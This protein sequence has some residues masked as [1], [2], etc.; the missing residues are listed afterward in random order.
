MKT[1][2]N[3]DLRIGNLVATGNILSIV[4][5]ITASGVTYDSLNGSVV[6]EHCEW[7]DV[8]GVELSKALLEKYGFVDKFD[9]DF[10]DE[11]DL[12]YDKI[13]GKESI[14]VSYENGKLFV[15]TKSGLELTHIL[16]F[17]QL[18]NLI[19]SLTGEELTETKNG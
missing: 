16:F 9:S 11:G 6:S 3:T 2:K 15:I 12:V 7:E 13:V 5:E 14:G 4:V 8:S 10:F 17:H 18:Q 1:M 19:Y